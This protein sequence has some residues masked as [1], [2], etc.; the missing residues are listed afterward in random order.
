MTASA[1]ATKAIQARPRVIESL[2][3]PPRASIQRRFSRMRVGTR[4]E[5]ARAPASTV[6]SPRTARSATM[7]HLGRRCAPT[8]APCGVGFTRSSCSRNAR[9]VHVGRERRVAPRAAPR[10]QVAGQRVEA[11][12]D[13]GSRQVLDQLPRAVLGVRAPEND[14]ARAAGDR[15]AGP[16][17]AGQRRGRPAVLQLGRQAALELA[18]VPRPEM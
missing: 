5:L 9:A 15:R 12:L 17:R 18:D 6:S 11:Q 2:T 16:V 4:V 14:E 7:L 10:R 1:G 8:R 3:P 13:V